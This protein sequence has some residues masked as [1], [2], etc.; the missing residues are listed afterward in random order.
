MA[1]VDHI[2]LNI[3][4]GLEDF[5]QLNIVYTGKAFSIDNSDFNN[6]QSL[7][8][9]I[10][11]WLLTQINLNLPHRIYVSY[12]WQEHEIYNT[13]IDVFG[14]EHL[15]LIIRK[16]F[17]SLDKFFEII[18]GEI[19][20]Y[21]VLII[22]ILQ[23]IYRH[24]EK[25]FSGIFAS[26]SCKTCGSLLFHDSD[27]D[28]MLCFDCDKWIEE[29]RYDYGSGELIPG[30]NKPSDRKKPP[31]LRQRPAQSIATHNSFTISVSTADDNYIY[32]IQRMSKS[33]YSVS[34]GS[35]LHEFNS[36]PQL[37]E[38]FKAEVEKYNRYSSIILDYNAKDYL[39]GMSKEIKVKPGSSKESI[40]EMILNRVVTMIIFYK[41]WIKIV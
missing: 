24:P 17:P 37:G 14:S 4:F 33:V 9:E 8:A 16:E 27:I 32:Q 7:T 35:C 25:I 12:F 34:N 13:G 18:I 5:P 41:L 31:V 40:V 15:L 22:E 11:D 36:I 1:G 29:P 39:E 23:I 6:V 19:Q 21:T 30:L 28:A 38:Y 20:D 26:K 3:N 2:R 10:S